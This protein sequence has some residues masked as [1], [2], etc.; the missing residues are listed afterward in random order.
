MANEIIKP[1]KFE[2]AKN[3]IHSLSE[4]LFDVS[5]QRFET[6]GGLFGWFNHKVTGE[7]I[8]RILVSPL[9]SALMFQNSIIRD[10]FNIADEV[11]K[12]L[13]SLDNE[14]IQAIIAAVKSAEI[15]SE[16]AKTAS[17]K[18]NTASGQALD[19]SR[20]AMDASAK[21]TEA[22]ED[23]KRT[24]KALQATVTVLKDFKEKAT[25]ELSSISSIENKVNLIDSKVES[26]EHNIGIIAEST[27]ELNSIQSDISNLKHIKDID[28]IWDDLNSFRE[29]I[30]EQTDRSA[31]VDAI[32]G[33]V[34]GH[35]A[36]LSAF[37]RQVDSFVEKVNEATARIE[38]DIESLQQYRA[39]LESYEHLG[40]VDT[41]WGDVE[42]HK[43]DL[44]SFH[45]Q[46]DSFVEKVEE[47]TARIDSDIES[48]QQY[49]A[50]L[51]SY[52]HLGDVDTIWSDVEV[53][54]EDLLGLHRKLDLFIEETHAEQERISRLMD[55]LEEDNK[56]AHLQFNK[57]LKIAYWIGGS[58]AGLAIINY[59]LQVLEVL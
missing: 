26:I 50:V 7:E 19:A 46:V 28:Q 23:I 1:H 47:A 39:L 56:E 33:D 49:R 18:A 32:W 37:H 38:G 25:S 59:I 24:I 54:K 31:V 42:G 41:I 8:N 36:D 5:L 58:A 35:K 55:H 20:K 22:Q 51:E 44:S 21:A 27:N 57:K 14:Y 9:Q 45:Q 15:A 29:V 13:E 40:D 6:E 48:L 16:Q 4:T 17:T 52:E 53:H 2:L 10:L 12:A 34:E 3:N 43:A 30:K 11:Y